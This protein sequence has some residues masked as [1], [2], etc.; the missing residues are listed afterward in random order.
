MTSWHV[1]TSHDRG[2]LAPHPTL[3]ND[4]SPRAPLS[5]Q[6]SQTSSDFTSHQLRGAQR[7]NGGFMTHLTPGDAIQV[8]V[9]VNITISTV[10]CV[11]LTM[12][13][14][15]QQ[16]Y[17]LQPSETFL[18][19]F[20][21][22]LNLMIAFIDV[23]PFGDRSQLICDIVTHAGDGEL[24][25]KWRDGAPASALSSPHH[26]ILPRVFNKNIKFIRK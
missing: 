17:T 4:S 7:V 12:S 14:S 13:Q 11:A 21:S 24:M 15:G 6:D 1:V 22:P 9:P 8:N 3:I 2:S 25:W 20:L 16:T 5:S 10:S 26:K 23:F 18:S 19:F